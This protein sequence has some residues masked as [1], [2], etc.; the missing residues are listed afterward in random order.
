MKYFTYFS[1]LVLCSCSSSIK[2]APSSTSIFEKF[3]IYRGVEGDYEITSG[4]IKTS[5]D[6]LGLLGVDKSKYTIAPNSS[7]SFNI[8]DDSVDLMYGTFMFDLKRE[9]LLKTKRFLIETSVDTKLYINEDF[10]N[11]ATVVVLEKGSFNISCHSR[12]NCPR[13]IDEE[14][15]SLTNKT[16]VYLNNKRAFTLGHGERIYLDNVEYTCVGTIESIKDNIFQ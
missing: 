7:V 2:R 1:I 3:K 15:R 4:K 6:R 9:H 14:Y 13:D 5:N 12:E 8:T 16:C 11:D 10:E